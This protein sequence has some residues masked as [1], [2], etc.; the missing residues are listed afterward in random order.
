M[1]NMSQRFV[2]PHSVKLVQ[3]PGTILMQHCINFTLSGVG[4]TGEEWI[5]DSVETGY[6]LSEKA[7][8]V[9]VS[10]DYDKKHRISPGVEYEVSLVLGEVIPKDSERMIENMKRLARDEFGDDC[11]TDLKGEHAFLLLKGLM[12]TKLELNG[13]SDIIVPHRFIIDSSNNAI[14]LGINRRNGSLRVKGYEYDPGR[15]L[16]CDSALAFVKYVYRH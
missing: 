1:N 16:G 13:L 6:V 11:A 14:V 7:R 15:E 4:F 2:E 3:H 9:L 12:S 5:K 8:E 10:A